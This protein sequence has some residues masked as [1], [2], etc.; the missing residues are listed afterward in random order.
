VIERGEIFFI[1]RGEMNLSRNDMTRSIPAEERDKNSSRLLLL[2][3]LL[4]VGEEFDCF[5]TH[6][7][8]EK[9]K[10]KREKKFLAHFADEE[11]VRSRTQRGEIR[12]KPQY[13]VAQQECYSFSPKNSVFR[14][15][16]IQLFGFFSLLY[17]GRRLR[18]MINKTRTMS[19]FSSIPSVGVILI[20]KL[21]SS[22]YL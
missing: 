8:R 6:T 11:V 1:V 12:Q 21:K 16:W 13:P 3:V 5:R 18:E 14:R 19:V 17:F 2:L 4:F 20:G 7:H 15:I 9:I 22:S 10:H